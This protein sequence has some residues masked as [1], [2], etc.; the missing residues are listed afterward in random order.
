MNDYARMVEQLSDLE[1]ELLLGESKQWGSWM[2][3]CGKGL[4]AKG[5]G[6]TANGSI[7]FDT[8]LA[9]E[10]IQILRAQKMAACP[11]PQRKPI[12]PTGVREL[13]AR[14]KASRGET[15]PMTNDVSATLAERGAR[16]GDFTH[17]ADIAQDLQ[18]A[19]RG[20]SGWGRLTPDKRQALTVIADKIA[21]ILNGDPEYK[22]NWHDI[23]GY[24]KLAEDRCK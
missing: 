7:M 17:H 8:P 12:D 11:D 21:R 22:D 24:A 5:L 20:C 2:M 23:C 6:T 19:M 15:P 9:L 1:K 3:S 14:D 13:I 4:I 16:Y 18:D 10:V